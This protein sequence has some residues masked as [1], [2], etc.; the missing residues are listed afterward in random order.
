M[1]NNGF[2]RTQGDPNWIV[3]K[4]IIIFSTTFN[5]WCNVQVEYY[6][7][8]I[9]Q[10][11]NVPTWIYWGEYNEYSCKFKP[12]AAHLRIPILVYILRQLSICLVIP[13]VFPFMLRNLLY[14]VAQECI[15]M[16]AW[17]YQSI[18][19]KIILRFADLMYKLRKNFI[20]PEG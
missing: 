5:R 16:F 8:N 4:H 15:I 3:Y 17:K 19:N 9:Q 14:S 6:L 1:E 11:V 10:Y 7:Y 13:L 2:E 12:D 18:V 20:K